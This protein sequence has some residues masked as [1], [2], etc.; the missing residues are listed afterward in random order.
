MKEKRKDSR[1]VTMVYILIKRVL[2]WHDG[3]T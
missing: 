2:G 3:K 1:A